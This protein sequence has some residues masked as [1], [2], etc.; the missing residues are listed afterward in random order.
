MPSLLIRWRRMFGWRSRIFAAPA[1][2]DSISLLKGG[3][4][5]ASL[6]FL[7]CSKMLKRWGATLRRR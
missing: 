7:R 5:M 3:Q 4:D 2:Y 6:H 1:I